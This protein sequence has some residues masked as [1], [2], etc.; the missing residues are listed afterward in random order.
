MRVYF[1]ICEF[2]SGAEVSILPHL[3]ATAR[4]PG[5]RPRHLAGWV[6]HWRRYWLHACFLTLVHKCLMFRHHDSLV[7]VCK[8]CQKPPYF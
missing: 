4:S 6:Q 5:L 7:D 8:L 1:Y 2:V 3:A